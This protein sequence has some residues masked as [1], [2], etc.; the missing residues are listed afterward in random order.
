MCGKNLF[1][2]ARKIPRRAVTVDSQIAM[3]RIKIPYN[4][5]LPDAASGIIELSC[6]RCVNAIPRIGKVLL[7]F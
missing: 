6:S 5:Q 2:V 4:R 1:V 3:N 7:G